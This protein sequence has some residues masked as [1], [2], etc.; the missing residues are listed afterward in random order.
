VTRV[1]VVWFKRDLR[2]FDH[3]ALAAAARRGPVL[4]LYIAEPGLWAQPD[5]AGRHWAFIA[6]CLRELSGDLAALGQPLVVRQGEAIPVLDG[7]L[8]RLPIGALWSHE[9]T[10]NGWTNA[11]DR[12]VGRFLRARGVPA[13]CP[14]TS[15]P[16]MAWCGPW[17]AG[18]AGPGLG[19][20]AWGRPWRRPPP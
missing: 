11:R 18:I 5:A 12:A 9:E 1:Q 2:V 4:P 8:E 6:E 15:S 3:A 19:S 7:L 20:S 16:R 14:G 17:S 10:G 13:G